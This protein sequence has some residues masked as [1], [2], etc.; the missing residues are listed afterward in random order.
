MTDKNGAEVIDIIE[1]FT[2]NLGI[3]VECIARAGAEPGP[4]MIGDLETAQWH[5]QREINRIKRDGISASSQASAMR[6]ASQVHQLGDSQQNGTV[7][8]DRMGDKYRFYNGAWEYQTAGLDN[9][10][11]VRFADILTD[12]GPYTA[13]ADSFRPQHRKD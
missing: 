2:F 10:E 4:G 5:L 7:W 1:R 11:P 13:V 3:A 6:A 12:F 8:Q 9:W